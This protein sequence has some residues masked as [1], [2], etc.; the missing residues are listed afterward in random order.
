[1]VLGIMHD[2][3]PSLPKYSLISFYQ[4]QKKVWPD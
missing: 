4:W 2:A 1:M 3:V